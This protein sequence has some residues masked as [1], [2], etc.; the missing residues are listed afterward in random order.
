MATDMDS[1]LNTFVEAQGYLNFAS[2]G[3]VSSRVMEEKNRLESLA[4]MGMPGAQDELNKSKPAVLKSLANLSGFDQSAISLVNNTSGGLLQVALGL[5][6]GELL[7]S[8]GEFPANLYPW[9]RAAALQRL[10]CREIGEPGVAVTPQLIAAH[11][12]PQVSAVA[13]SAVDFRTGYRVDLSAIREVIGDRL[14]IVDGIQG[15][16]IT[17]MDWTQADA[18]VVGGQKWLRCGWNTGFIALSSRGLERIAPVI[19]NWAGVID[20]YDY[21]GLEHPSLPGAEAFGITNLSPVALGGFAA[22]L[23]LV[24]QAG[25]ANIEQRIQ[26]KVAGFVRDAQEHNLNLLSDVRPGKHAGI[27]VV[28]GAGCDT[29]ALQ[30][31]LSQHGFT[32]TL[33]QGGRIR[34]SIHATTRAESLSQLAALLGERM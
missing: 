30:A 4:A 12:T 21:D 19:S 23:A 26:Q 33:H 8:K 25:V 7:V 27:V 14:L 3:P 17:T 20:P 18:L 6:G 10:R 24:E 28:D 2:F 31:R 9:R 13:V 5:R 16:G 22:G 29:A 15:F 34:V 11:L 1:Y 32:V